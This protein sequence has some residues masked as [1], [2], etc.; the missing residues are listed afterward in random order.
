[1]YFQTRANEIEN[2]FELDMYN[3]FG[4]NNTTKWFWIFPWIH[5][6]LYKYVCG[7]HKSYTIYIEGVFFKL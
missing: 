2:S 6:I 7:V 3:N 4:N 1:M 5:H